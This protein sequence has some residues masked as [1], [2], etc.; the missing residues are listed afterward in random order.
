M[1]STNK[2]YSVFFL[3][4][5]FFIIAEFPIGVVNQHDDSRSHGG[6]LDK[7]LLLLPEVL[8]FKSINDILQYR[9]VL[10]LDGQ[11]L[12]FVKEQFHSSTEF[13]VYV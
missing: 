12:L 11:L 6:A 7:Q 13:N 2:T 8:G 3:N 1:Q 5:V 9:S 10:D 4:C